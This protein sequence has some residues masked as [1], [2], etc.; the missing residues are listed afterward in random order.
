METYYEYFQTPEKIS[1]NKKMK[2]NIMWKNYIIN[3]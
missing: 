2:C 1:F 3:E